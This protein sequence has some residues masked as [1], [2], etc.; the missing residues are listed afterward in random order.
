MRT[1][2]LALLLGFSLLAHAQKPEYQIVFHGIGDN[3]EFASNKAYSQTILGERTSLEIGTTLEE[4]HRF[5]I[6]LSHLFEFG[7]E[8]DEQKPKII[9]YY[10]YQDDQKTF[11]FGAFPRMKLIDFPLALLTD[12]LKYYRP[13]IE[14]LYGSFRWDWGHQAGWI[15]WTGRQ[16]DTRREAFL[17]AFSGEMHRRSFF[18]QNYFTLFHYAETAL[19]PEGEHIIDNMG[20]TLYLG[21]DLEKLLPLTKTYVKLGVLGSSIRERSVSDGFEHALSLT[22]QF[23]GQLKQFALRATLHQGEGHQLMNGDR[24]YRSDSYLRTDI[25]WDFINGRHIRGHFNLSFHLTEGKLDHSQQ[26]S[27]VYCFGN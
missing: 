22:G 16:T 11:Y 5:R 27:L 3:R 2:I 4:H 17:A 18:L 9:A 26:L 25:I 6:G 13:N 8:M 23:Y 12:T 20:L 24:F 1:A 14:G 7:S 15:D 21:A 19:E 10:R